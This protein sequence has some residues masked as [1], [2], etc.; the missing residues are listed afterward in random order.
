M[1]RSHKALNDKSFKIFA[2]GE[3]SGSALVLKK[4]FAVAKR[5]NK[6]DNQ[7]LWDYRFRPKKKILLGSPKNPVLG[8]FTCKIAAREAFFTTAEI[9]F[10]YRYRC[11]YEKKR[12]LHNSE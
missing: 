3:K 7:S 2:Q 4:I 10:L 1:P 12:L 8:D 5:F 9:L 6:K 11:K